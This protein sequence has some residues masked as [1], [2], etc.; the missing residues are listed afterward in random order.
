MRLYTES[1]DG[2]FIKAKESHLVWHHHD[3]DPSFGP[4]KAK[5]LLDHLKNV[6]AN[7]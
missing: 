5:E 1:T 7:H 4:C 2:S 6:H 3:A